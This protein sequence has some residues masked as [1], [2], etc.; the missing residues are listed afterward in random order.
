MNPTYFNSPKIRAASLPAANG[1]FSARQLAAFYS[2]RAGK[3]A[4]ALKQA[5]PT[6]Q[7]LVTDEALLQGGSGSIRLG[8]MVY[9]DE[10]S[11]I[12]FGHSGLGGSIALCQHD[13]NSGE[14]LSIA[15][16]TNRLT[17]DPTCTRQILRQIFN[18]L[19]R[20][21]PSAFVRE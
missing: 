18:A 3:L 20:P 10:G 9:A 13:L 15:I 1:F 2:S 7:T 8:Y 5:G 17:F 6:E 14:T 21:V 12:I 11:S 4:S 19:K 16:T